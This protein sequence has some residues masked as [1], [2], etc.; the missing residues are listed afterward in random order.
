LLSQERQLRRDGDAER[1]QQADEYRDRFFEARYNSSYC[2]YATAIADT[3][4]DKRG[5]LL[6]VAKNDIF[7]VYSVVSQNFGGGVWKNRNERLL[8]KIQEA[9]NQPAIGLLE[10][11]GRPSADASKQVSTK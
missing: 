2:V 11:K 10:F 3:D 7:A 1:I 6:N 9:L 4:V 8:Q 5:K